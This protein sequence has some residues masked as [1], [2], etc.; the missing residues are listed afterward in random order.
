MSVRCP[1]EDCSAEAEQVETVFERH[2]GEPEEVTEVLVCENE[3]QVTVNYANPIVAEHE[4][5]SDDVE[6]VADGS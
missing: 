4:D 1:L 5:L 2:R 6:G 3:H